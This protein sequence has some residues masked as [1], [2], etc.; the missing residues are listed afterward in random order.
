LTLV[1]GTVA[2]LMLVIFVVVA[3]AG[4][5]LILRFLKEDALSVTRAFAV[6]VL[7]TLIYG[8]NGYVQREDQLDKSI[9]QF[10]RQERRVRE[11]SVFDVDGKVISSSAAEKRE[12]Q[13]APRSPESLRGLAGPVTSVRRDWTHGWIVSAVLPLKIGQRSWG[14]LEM[15]LDAEPAWR[16][17]VALFWTL[18]FA[19]L[20]VTGGVLIV[21]NLLV[22]RATN[23]LTA[24]ASAMDRFDPEAP[25]SLDLPA[26]EGE[27][28]T[29]IARFRLLRERL[30]QSRTELVEAQKQIYQAEKLASIGRLASGVAHE[31]NNPLNGIRHCVSAM[32]D[33]PEDA[34]QTAEYLGLIDEGLAHIEGVVQKLLQFARKQSDRQRPVDVNEAVRNVLTLLDYR[35][36][37]QKVTVE[38]ALAEGLPAVVA[39]AQLL[40]EVFMNLLLNALDAVRPGGRVSMATRADGPGRVAVEVKDDG[41]GID[42]ADLPHLFEPFFTTKEPGKGT[43]LGLSVAQ[44]IVE[45]HGG[46][47]EAASR[48]G[49]GAL[50]SV[51]LPAAGG[52]A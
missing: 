41:P 43:G 37:Q 2:L 9:D 18:A 25:G 21:L 12:F 17:L 20:A 3:L 6:P 35:S 30:A 27:V 51:R 48:P 13:P 5:G 42:P 24:L 7:E 46:S 1:G 8:E 40:Q 31:I 29:V 36:R 52:T 28:G 22:S 4:R 34:A 44:G 38:T 10:L 50:F 32:K 33:E 47:I 11:I 15:S 49:E 16:R 26:A 45:A 39:D 19:G 23:S 14:Y